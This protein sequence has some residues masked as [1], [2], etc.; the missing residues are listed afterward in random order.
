MTTETSRFRRLAKTR[1]SDYGM[2]LL[3]TALGL[4]LRSFLDPVLGTKAPFS[5]SYPAV[6]LL[7]IYV[8]MG[9]A[10]LGAVLGL[11]ADT[12]WFVSPRH[13]W[14]ALDSMQAI[15]S[16]AIYL[17]ACGLII[18]AAESS[19]RAQVRLVRAR[20][21]LQSFLEAAATGLTHCSRDLRYVA[22]NPAYAQ[23]AG[24]PAEQIEGRAIVE[25][26]GEKSWE[27]IRPHVDRVL[28]GERVEYETALTFSPGGLHHLHVVYTP[29]RNGAG[30]VVGWF[31]SVS[32]MTQLKRFEKKLQEVERMAAAGQLAASLAHEINNPLNSV[33]NL[34]YLIEHHEGVSAEAAK[35]VTTAERELTR[36]SRIV[37]QSLS[38]YRVG[39][40]AGELDLASIVEESIQI[41]GGRMER[42]G[43]HISKEITAG[44]TLIGFPGEIR[45]VI[46]SLLLN[47]EE[48]MPDG[49]RLRISVRHSS[50]WRDHHEPGV[51]LTIADTGCGISR[52]HFPHLF[53][54]FFTTKAEKGSGLGLFVTRGIILKH[55][56]LVKFRSRQMEAT[57]GTVVS[58]FWPSSGVEKL[59]ERRGPQQVSVSRQTREIG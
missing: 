28:R 50:N 25:V 10:I 11:V 32:D 44:T 35:L 55:K 58:V 29:E 4:L 34:L 45:Q 42:A 39:A 24:I 47:A 12:Y 36:V 5:F 31:A 2:M 46:D 27:I 57:S 51:R 8:G 22:V 56:G 52:E 16:S 15:V 30:E 6:T 59:S 23:M 40:V 1:W 49:G 53:E 41:F 9:P 3:V 21:L 7:A 17:V 20:L 33:T 43:I 14:A 48:A 18:A 26:M 13:S 38:Y 19:R 37:K 54:P